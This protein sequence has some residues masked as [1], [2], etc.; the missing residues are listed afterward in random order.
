M[1][2]IH[3]NPDILETGLINIV[4][5]VAFLIYALKPPLQ[6][7]LEEREKAID[8]AIQNANSRLKE[9][10]RRLE[11]AQK[12]YQQVQIAKAEIEKRFEET[13][14]AYLKELD[15]LILEEIKIRFMKSDQSYSVI[16]QKIVEEIILNI[17]SRVY[18]Q[19]VTI[20]K[21]YLNSKKNRRQYM[22]TRLDKLSTEFKKG[23][24]E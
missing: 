17:N 7:S 11:E 8:E 4:I 16:T 21:D 18:D 1:Q 24:F 5:L 12:Q 13:R 22:D 6:E 10:E 20:M 19:L 14:Q 23:D 15:H 2:N 9:A 3:L